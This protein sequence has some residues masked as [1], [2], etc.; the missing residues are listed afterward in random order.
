MHTCSELGRS[1]RDVH[2]NACAV[3]RAADRITTRLYL[4]WGQR[5]EP[6]E[7]RG[8]ESRGE[9]YNGYFKTY[10]TYYPHCTTPR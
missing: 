6:E 7:G 10:T 2:S 8:V 5:F 4:V 1:A 9:V 3:V